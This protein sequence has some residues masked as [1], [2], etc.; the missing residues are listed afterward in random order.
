M[1]LLSGIASTADILSLGL[2]HLL[3]NKLSLKHSLNETISLP[4]DCSCIQIKAQNQIISAR[5]NNA[6]FTPRQ[7]TNPLTCLTVYTK[8]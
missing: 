3:Q 8:H 5:K 4:F 2:F 1:L 7:T 6:P